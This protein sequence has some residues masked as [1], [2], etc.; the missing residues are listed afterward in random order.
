M[1]TD[2][3]L[4]DLEANDWNSWFHSLKKNEQIIVMIQSWTMLEISKRRLYDRLLGKESTKEFDS[5]MQR[6]FDN[7]C[8][9]LGLDPEEVNHDMNAIVD[10]FRIDPDDELDEHFDLEI[11]DD[12]Y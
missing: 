9:V 6:S 8:E 10:D 7:T 11:E 1:S 3:K 4:N 2:K 12:G 5:E